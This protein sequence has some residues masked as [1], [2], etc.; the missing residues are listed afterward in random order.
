[1]RVV[2]QEPEQRLLVEP[3]L[4]RGSTRAHRSARSIAVRAMAPKDDGKKTLVKVC[5][6]TT[7]EDAT[8]AA[9]AGAHWLLTTPLMV[10]PGTWSRN[11]SISVCHVM[12]MAICTA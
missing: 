5:G 10:K 8:Q 4:D 2:A 3:R 1:M 12:T 7:P 11:S 9:S 6:V